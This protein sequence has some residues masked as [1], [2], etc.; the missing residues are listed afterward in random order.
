MALCMIVGGFVTRLAAATFTLA[1]THS[2]ERTAWQEEWRIDGERL[3][4]VTARVKGSG[5]GMEPGPDAVAEDGW[6]RWQP[7]RSVAS[8]TLARSHAVPDWHLCVE[9]DCR[10]LAGLGDSTATVELRPCP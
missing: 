9:D 6:W 3:V 8:L 2:V 7:D 1:W 5:A 10:T 4:L